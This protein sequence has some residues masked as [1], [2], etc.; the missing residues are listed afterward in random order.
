MP[1]GRPIPSDIFVDTQG[2][3]PH[4]RSALDPTGIDAQFQH[5]SF[6]IYRHHALSVL[7]L[8]M[9]EEGCV[10]RQHGMQLDDSSNG[11]ISAVGK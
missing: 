4:S 10:V 8:V 3:K 7:H 11:E 1:V 5:Q 2:T 6:T 9:G